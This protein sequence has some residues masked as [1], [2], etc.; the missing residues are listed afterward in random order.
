MGSHLVDGTGRESTISSWNG[1][2]RDHGKGREQVGSRS[3]TGR[4]HSRE[5]GLEHSRDSIGN[6]DG[7]T[8]GSTVG[9]SVAILFGIRPE[10]AVRNCWEHD[11]ERWLET[12]VETIAMRK[13]IPSAI[14]QLIAVIQ[15]A[16]STYWY[17]AILCV[18]TGMV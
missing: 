8:V 1:K 10:D 15:L 4:E 5:I 13:M 17:D 11:R 7:K 14:C 16:Q 6:I 18:R 9:K 12:A 3:G 2:G